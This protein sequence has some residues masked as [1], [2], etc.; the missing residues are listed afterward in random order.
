[1][2]AIKQVKDSNENM[3]NSPDLKGLKVLVV[4]DNADTLEL[5]AI[6]LEQ[7]GA[8]VITAVSAGEAIGVINQF[9]LDILISDIAMPKEDGYSLI[10]KV[11][12]LEAERGSFLPAVAMSAYIT[13]GENICPLD[14]GFQVQ[15]CKPVDPIELVAIVAKLTGRY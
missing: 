2:K 7:Y 5:S 15:V 6:I 3:N 1:L 12:T 11:R 14:S 4:D 10:R 8:Q 13:D 9:Q